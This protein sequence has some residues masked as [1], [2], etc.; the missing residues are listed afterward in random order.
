MGNLEEQET[1]KQAKIARRKDMESSVVAVNKHLA[2][3]VVKMT[4]SELYA[5]MHP[6]DAEFFTIRRSNT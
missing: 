5:N 3:K 4:A 1:E 6:Y 2:D